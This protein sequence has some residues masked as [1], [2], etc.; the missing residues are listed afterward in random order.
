MIAMV[1]QPIED[2]INIIEE[3]NIGA[4]DVDSN[5]AALTTCIEEMILTVK[6]AKDNLYKEKFYL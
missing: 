3:I 2:I 4:I 6:S 5:D 1:G